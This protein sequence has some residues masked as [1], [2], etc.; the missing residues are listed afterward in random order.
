MMMVAVEKLEIF[1]TQKKNPFSTLFA[2]DTFTNFYTVFMLV[3]CFS[4]HFTIQLS[5]K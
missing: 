1:Y 3:F 2:F 4:I 5:L